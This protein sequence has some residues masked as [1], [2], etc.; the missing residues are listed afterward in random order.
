MA[1]PGTDPGDA[2]PRG[3]VLGAYRIRALLG[4]G[5]FGLVYRAHHLELG[6]DV[7][8]KEFFPTELAVR[9]G[10]S[11]QP[12]RPESEYYFQDGL[13][14]FLEE[15][16]RLE[17][18]RDCPGIVSCRDLFRANGTAYMVMDFVE[19]LPLS[20]LLGQRETHGQPFTERDLL[21]VIRPLLAGL[22][23]IHRSGVYHRDIKPSNILIRR[24]DGLPIL[25]DF[26]AAK[27]ET[28]GLTKS[29]APYTDGY[30]AWEQVGEGQIGPWTDVYGVGAVMWRMVA[31]GA[32]PFH[33]PN[34]LPV[35][36]RAHQT[37]QGGLDPM[38]KA[39]K[40]GAGRFAQNL[41]QT[42]DA[43]TEIQSA[44]RIQNCHEILQRIDERVQVPTGQTWSQRRNGPS[45]MEGRNPNRQEFDQNYMHLDIIERTRVG[46]G[47][48]KGKTWAEVVR[49]DP[50]Y[51]RWWFTTD[52]PGKIGAPVL[53]AL[54]A[55]LGVAQEPDNHRK[56]VAHGTG[57]TPMP[58]AW[59]DSG[60]RSEFY[61]EYVAIGAIP[62]VLINSLSEWNSGQVADGKGNAQA[63][64]L[65]KALSQTAFLIRRDR[66]GKSSDTTR[67]AAS[68]IEKL[69]TR[70][71]TP[72]P[73]LGVERE[74]LKLNDLEDTVSELGA[75]DP[76]LGWDSDLVA[77]HS[78]VVSGVIERANF[79]ADPEINYASGSHAPP[80][81]CLEKERF[82]NHWV[83]KELGPTAGH[84]F[85]PQVS[86]RMLL[87]SEGVSVSANDSRR[88][89][90]LFCH[91]ML[92]RPLAIEI[93]H[94]NG[95]GSNR[96]QSIP[97]RIDFVRVPTEELIRES[98]P[99]LAGIRDRLSKLFVHQELSEIHRRYARLIADCTVASKV[100]FALAGALWRGWLRP[101]RCW[102]VRIAGTRS[103]SAF[104]VFDLLDMLQAI[105]AIYG[106]PVTPTQCLVELADSDHAL[107]WPRAESGKA[108]S[109]TGKTNSGDCDQLVIAAETLCG[110]S[111]MICRS[112]I[113]DCIIRSAYLP[114]DLAIS[115][116]LPGDL[117]RPA[118]M[119][120]YQEGSA[121]HRALRLFLR[122]LYRK[123]EFLEGQARAIL[124][125]LRHID[126]I[127][128]LPTGGGKSIV[129][130]LAG[131]LMPGV[132]LVVDPLIALMEDQVEGLQAYGID[133]T[134]AIFW[135]GDRAA[136]T[137]KI[138]LMEVGQFQFVLVSPE[139]LQNV[140][141]RKAVHGLAANYP[142]NLAVIDEA[143]CVSEWGH[144]FRPAYL[145]LAN[146]L[147]IFTSSDDGT[148]PPLLALTGTASRAVLRDMVD[149]L[150]I[151]RNNSDALI[152]PES[153]DRKEIKF[154]IIRTTPAFAAA[155]LRAELRRLAAERGLPVTEYY[156]PRLR[157]T[158]SGIV[159]VPTVRGKTGI[160]EVLDHVTRVT[161]AKVTSYSG[162]APHDDDRSTWNKT[163]RHN[164]QTFKRNEAPVL[165]ATKAFGMG[166]DKPN[167]RYTIHFGVPSSLEQ[168]YQEAGRAG[169]DRQQAYSTLIL[170]ELSETR[171]DDLLHPDLEIEELRHLHRDATS[172][173]GARDDITRALFFHLSS[174]RGTKEEVED[175]WCLI[176]KVM[177]KPALVPIK[178]E[179]S[180]DNDKKRK[181]KAIYRL[182]KLGFVKDY[183]VDSGTR[184]FEI[185]RAGFDFR[186]FRNRL[187]NYV[188][189]VAP[190]KLA[191][192][193]R[194]I[195]QI[196][197]A[198]HHRALL[199]LAAVHVEF[200]YDEIER[201]RRRA[202]QEAILLARQSESD[203]EVR[204]R[205]L[206]YLQEG[207]GHEQIGE[208]VRREQVDL[209]LWIDLVD[210][211]GNPIEA[212][213]L[214]GLCIRALESSP[215]HPGLLLTRGVV[216]ALAS[217][218]Y[219]NVAST[220]IAR[221]IIVGIE[222]YD[223]AAE[224]F[225]GVIERLFGLSSAGPSRPAEAVRLES[226]L[227]MA[228][229]D[230][231]E[232][233]EHRFV[234]A[235]V[236]RRSDQCGNWEALSILQWHRT[237]Q[238]VK[239]LEDAV[240]TAVQDLG[241]FQ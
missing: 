35:Q 233:R 165:V 241:H 154:R 33:P 214:R 40:L 53:A 168:Y 222:K 182:Y 183:T 45:Q 175:V 48:Y 126:T 39:E 97:D 130:Q 172:D 224:H 217:D 123:R 46:F 226:A 42:V 32:P 54:K 52:N 190:G 122:H 28:A 179:F 27:Q 56:A 20:R 186:R 69:L 156:K 113:P 163:K 161:S 36:R 211:I 135:A 181:E 232:V 41:L 177:D 50:G 171:S 5:G 137:R 49:Q 60:D 174:F 25:I 82:L 17:D 157:N 205:L 167:I 26:G 106:I 15:A 70:G 86:L 37:M 67:F 132:T 159:F 142:I 203:A 100:Q 164:A 236:K 229:V 114:V 145:S 101:G 240:N 108:D 55:A 134:A 68:L 61:A 66:I 77:D 116:K 12:N 88:I 93:G 8:V 109:Q 131:L 87:E 31:G 79:A 231:L 218:Y 120:D 176:G 99:N 19:G 11:V 197:P 166:I 112:D 180:T 239:Q 207:V 98:G 111:H 198:D 196:D 57:P 21:G 237:E 3:S 71:S 216:E 155:R 153:F 151:D 184:E 78:T 73:S 140:A 141:F 223:I 102:K 80:A 213:E 76:E 9:L 81:G 158:N 212:G 14:R 90:F 118:V 235:I 138:R 187:L 104:G 169:R 74:A 85:I 230:L 7:A 148:T 202:I 63:E 13:G 47:K 152:R 162:K 24:S 188:R 94:R 160:Y 92:F 147:R 65:N 129:Y 43:C 64:S 185:R 91:P 136:Q 194:R 208:L 121:I 201:A 95:A 199:G 144:D 238:L 178:L 72:L 75:D 220:N 146:S 110:L 96:G 124:N 195:D 225:E 204:K 119:R 117:R 189:N 228:L 221:S 4:C 29:M 18:F 2:L 143:H 107:E 215:D 22:Q 59:Q 206:D 44:Q 139:R 149:D 38:P 30:A 58:V 84:W 51:V 83:P 192:I 193:R 16:K 234:E 103:P 227:T 210:K 6:I 173:Y 191:S 89:D 10:P 1:S 34:P 200:T 133:R 115:P 105:E 150:E 23:V 128:L 219:W 127:V 170:G 62:G 209:Q 125:A